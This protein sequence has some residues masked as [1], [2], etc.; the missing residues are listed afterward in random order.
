MLT[1][2]AWDKDIIKCD[3]VIGDI[4]FNVTP[5]VNDVEITGRKMI[6]QKEYWDKYMKEKKTGKKDYFKLAFISRFF[7]LF[8]NIF[9]LF[10]R[11]IHLHTQRHSACFFF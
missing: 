8:N 11:L 9:F 2:Q 6:L 7:V 4:V 1:V 10:F 5:L 3:D